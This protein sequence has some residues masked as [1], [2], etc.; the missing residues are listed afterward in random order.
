MYK[1]FRDWV[2]ANWK[3]G[4]AAF[5]LKLVKKGAMPFKSVAPHQREGL[6]KA[7]SGLYHKLF[8]MPHFAGSSFRFD[9][10]KPFDSFFLQ[11]AGYVVPIWYFPRERKTA[12]VIPVES[13]L[14]MEVAGTRKSMTEEMARANATLTINL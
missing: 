9:A 4:S 8:D 1:P 3:G 5:E 13:F 10:K 7:A 12:Y 14:Q 6:L 11:G 2:E